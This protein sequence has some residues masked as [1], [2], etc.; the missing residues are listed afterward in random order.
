MIGF[1]PRDRCSAEFP[2]PLAGEGVRGRTPYRDPVNG[3]IIAA[4]LAERASATECG[5][6]EEEI[7]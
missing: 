4:R 3:A 6:I 5:A 1:Y 2:S 7:S